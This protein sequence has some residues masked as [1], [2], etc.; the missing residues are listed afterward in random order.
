VVGADGT[1]YAAATIPATE[2]DLGRP[3]PR[4]RT[5]FAL[6]AVDGTGRVVRT[7]PGTLIVGGY[8]NTQMWVR[9]ASWGTAYAVDTLGGL[10]G[11]FGDGTQQYRKVAGLSGPPAIADNGRIFVAANRGTVGFDL[12]ASGNPTAALFEQGSFGKAPAVGPDGLLYLGTRHGLAAVDQNGETRWLFPG[13]PVTPVLDDQ[14]LAYFSDKNR[15]VALDASGS[16]RWHYEAPDALTDPVFSPEKVM[17]VVGQSGLVHAIGLDGGRRWRF[18]LA[19][20]TWSAPGVGPDGTAYLSDRQGL[21]T[22]V[23]PG[24]TPRWSMKFDHVVG[25]AAAGPDGTVYVQDGAG[26]LLAVTPP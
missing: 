25:R 19:S 15:L 8:S 18:P 13:G 12:Q 14:G 21:M 26:R 20:P 7:L 10:Y 16:E 4:G 5:R 6:L 17:L 9:M 24:G 1:V 23:A 22:A 11:M 3:L 2:D